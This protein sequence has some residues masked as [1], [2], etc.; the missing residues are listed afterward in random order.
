M[1]G[2]PTRQGPPVE[3]ELCTP[4]GVALLR[5]LVANWGRPPTGFTV[6]RIGIGAGTKDFPGHPNILRVMI[7]EVQTSPPGP[8]RAT[9]GVVGFEPPAKVQRLPQPG[10]NSAA[11][12]TSSSGSAG[13]ACAEGS[14]ETLGAT[15]GEAQEEKATETAVPAAA[16]ETEHLPGLVTQ[17]LF[18][19]EANLDDIGAED[20]A[21]ALERLL[22][23]VIS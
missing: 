19:I 20:V 15:P 10:N 7:G 21:Y 1:E 11:A 8:S 14:V 13:D 4:T 3:G 18:V 6:Q 22:A 9:A 17:Q 5:A 12:G 23:Q 2:V 16:G